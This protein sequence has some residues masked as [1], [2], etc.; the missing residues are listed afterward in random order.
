LIEETQQQLTIQTRDWRHGHHPAH[1]QQHQGKED[2]ALELLNLQAVLEGLEILAE[3]GKSYSA[4]GASASGAGFGT[5]NAWHV[6]P[7][8]S[9]AF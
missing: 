4:T 8:A 5:F 6:P 2:P 9:I 1:H 3:H 7:A